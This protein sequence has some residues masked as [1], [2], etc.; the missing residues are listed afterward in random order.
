M[1]YKNF[2]AYYLQLKYNIRIALYLEDDAKFVSDADFASPSSRWNGMMRELPSNF[3]FV[4]MGFC[5]GVRLV[6]TEF[7]HLALS[8]E[9]RCTDA[10]LS[11]RKGCYNAF[12]T[13]PIHA[14]HDHQMNEIGFR[15]RNLVWK[16][17][18][19]STVFDD[20]HIYFMEPFYATQAFASSKVGTLT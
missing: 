14:P 11:S 13:L 18:D 5:T 12:R 6:P 20:V 15:E 8:Q 1:S 4:M 17:F 2:Y 19:N 10:Y 7:K 16:M 3:D 9:S